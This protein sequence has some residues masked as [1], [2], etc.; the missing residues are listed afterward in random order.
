MLGSFGLWDPAEI[1]QADVAQ[2]VAHQGSFGD[3]TVKGRYTP[4][5]V[6]YV[7]LVAIGFKLLGVNELA[8][9]LPLALSGLL[10]LLIAYRVGRRVASERAGLVAGF[11]LA[12]T[13]TFLFQ[14]RQLASDIVF[15]TAILA[16]IGG[17]TA[18]IAPKEGAR[19]RWDLAIGTT[20]LIAATL[21]RG[22]LLGFGLPVLILGIALIVTRKSFAGEMTARDDTTSDEE[23]DDSEHDDENTA[24][25]NGAKAPLPLRDALKSLA[26]ALLIAGGVIAVVLLSIKQGKYLI[27]GGV[28]R[29]VALPPTFDKALRDF[30]FAF[31][32]WFA[33]LPLMLWQFVSDQGEEG[34][35]SHDRGSFA[36]LVIVLAIIFGYAAAVLWPG[37]F[38]KLRMPTLPLAA[39]GVGLWA[40]EVYNRGDRRPFWGVIAAGLILALHQDFV[41]RPETLAFSHLIEGARYPKD[42]IIKIPVRIFGLGLAA[43]F[44]LAL[45]GP[46]QHIVANFRVRFVGGIINFFA[47]L[48]DRVGGVLR[49]LGGSQGRYLYIASAAL[50]LI[51]AGWTSLWLTPELSYHMSNKELFQT[52]HRCKKPGERLAQYRVS[53]RGAAYYNH[54]QVD[55]IRDQNALFKTLRAPKRAF[56]LMPASYLGSI[57]QA[58]RQRHVPYH[59]LDDRNSHY[60]IVS[61]KLGNGCDKDKNPLRALVHKTRQKPQHKAYVNWENKVE[62]YG[63]DLPKSVIRGGSFKIRF[64]FRVLKRLAANY[65]I[66]IHFDKPASRFHGDHKPLGGKYP[67]QYWMP[68]DYIIDPKEVDIPLLTTASGRYSIMM[69]FWQGSKRSKIVKGPNDGVNRARV[70]YL[71]VR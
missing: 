5:P 20:G 27:L 15:F 60:L 44:F 11:I 57:D 66:F 49:Y 16:A 22:L 39:L 61:N 51:F 31:F 62:L 10:A 40:A 63:Y 28:Y 24:H 21:T 34:R 17:M 45:S 36:K 64:H 41:L 53:G 56:V 52:Y 32:P 14:T 67:T 7:W 6:L 1:K 54:G 42:L 68:G 70:G 2:A 3:I 69:G 30:G 25:N 38:G 50:A 26:I 35:S 55:T 65:K 4:R 12:T 47:R 59:V 8:G 58:A 43:L 9:R 71:V 23:A 19:S 13:P 48:I 18:F 46:P 37:F 33:V 29:K